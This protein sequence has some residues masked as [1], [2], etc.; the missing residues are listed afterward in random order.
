MVLFE[1]PLLAVLSAVV[2]LLH[3]VPRLLCGKLSFILEIVNIALHIALISA[4]L[5][6]GVP[7]SEVTLVILASVF[8]YT[9]L[10]LISDRIGRYNKKTA[11]DDT[12]ADAVSLTSGEGEGEI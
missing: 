5:I 3:I 10:Y 1:N 6:F 12:L 2:I 8:I 9:L 7:F 11:A 4:M